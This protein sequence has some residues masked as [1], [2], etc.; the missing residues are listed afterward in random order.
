MYSSGGIMITTKAFRKLALSFPGATEAPHFER[1]SFRV[2]TKIFA[3]LMEKTSVATLRLTPEQQTVFMEMARQAFTPVP[4][5]W[6]LQGWTFM[7]LDKAKKAIVMEAL[8]IAYGGIKETRKR[9]VSRALE[10]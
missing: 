6:G 10:S 3:T 1:T 4:G 8:D 2:G 9:K 7:D 5:K